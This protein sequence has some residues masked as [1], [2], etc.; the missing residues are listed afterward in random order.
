[1]SPILIAIVVSVLVISIAHWRKWLSQSGAAAALVVGTLTLGL[2]GPLWG[3]LLGLFFVSSSLLSKFKPKRKRQAEDEKFAKGSQRDMWQV[4]ANGGIGTAL[5]VLSS[6][7]PSPLWLYTFVGVMATVNADTWATEL[8]TLSKRLPRLIT[9]GKPVERGTSG[10][11]SPFGTLATVLGGLLIGTAAA[12]WHWQAAWVLL[13]AVGGLAGSLTDSLLGAT[14][15]L[16]YWDDVAHQETEQRMKRG[17]ELSVRRGW[18]WVTNDVVNLTASL[19]GGAV[20][21]I[22]GY[23][24]M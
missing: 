11:V 3:L 18:R 12:L 23:L 1:M 2:G 9:S 14:V 17:R 13:G 6:V 24:F 4:L 15:Q 10:A 20:A 7:L 5:A 22:L 21:A 16:I 8:G 19:V